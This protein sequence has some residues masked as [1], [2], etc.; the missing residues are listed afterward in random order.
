MVTSIENG[1]EQSSNLYKVCYIYFI[2]CPCENTMNLSLALLVNSY[3]RLGSSAWDGN[4]PKRK[5]IFSK[6]LWQFTNI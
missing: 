4:Q 5:T 1:T 6:E 3:N 2:L